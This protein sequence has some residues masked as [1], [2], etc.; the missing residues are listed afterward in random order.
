LRSLRR[1]KGAKEERSK[2]G[3]QRRPRSGIFFTPLLLYSFSSVPKN[4][5]PAGAA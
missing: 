3:N 2:E 4:T 5:R 1:S